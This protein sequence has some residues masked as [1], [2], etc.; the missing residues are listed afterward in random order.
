[1]MSTSFITLKDKLTSALILARPDFNLT[2]SLQTDAS[3]TGICAVLMQI[4][5]EGQ[6]RVIST[7]FCA[8]SNHNIFS[9]I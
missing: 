7:G 2:F 9:L 8:S 6:E 4:Q 3:E 1:M 5:E